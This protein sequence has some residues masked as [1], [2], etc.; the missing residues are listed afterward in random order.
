MVVSTAHRS[1]QSSPFLTVCFPVLERHGRTV[2]LP[3]V[4]VSPDVA[5]TPAATRKT[6]CGNALHLDKLTTVDGRPAVIKPGTID[7]VVTSP[8]YWRKRDY[9]LAQQLG[10]EATACEYAS[11]LVDALEE[12]YRYLS[13]TGS[14][15]LNVGDT[16]RNKSLQC[17]PSLIESEARK[18]RLHIRNR[19]VWVKQG[20]RPEPAQDRLSNR[21]EYIIH[22]VKNGYYYDLFGYASEYSK[23]KRGANP[24]DVWVIGQTLNKGPHLAPFPMEVAERAIRLACPEFVCT[25][26]GKPRTRKVERTLNGLDPNR[27]QA[28]RAL[29]LMKQAGLT[30]AHIAAI[31]A[32]GISDVGK[33]L[34]FQNGTGRNKAEVKKLAE[35]AKKA[36]GG[37]FREFTFAKRQHAGWANCKCGAPFRCGLV[38]DPFVGT[39]ATLDAAAKLGRSSIGIDLD[40]EMAKLAAGDPRLSSGNRRGRARQTSRTKNPPAFRRISAPR[41]MR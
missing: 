29:E 24:G 36:L 33:A 9:G 15:F 34:K 35:E 18:R 32:T 8:P 17:V 21:Y 37:Y 28:R 31:R 16:Y 38:L 13:D 5:E 7:L 3:M 10:Q 22:F 2:T 40:L 26:C 27:P 19:I 30:D 1:L 14:V 39:G 11:A 12:W 23:D 20:G 4:N 41:A 25:Q 6:F